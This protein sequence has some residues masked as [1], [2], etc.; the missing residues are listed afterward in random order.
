[1]NRLIGLILFLLFTTSSYA[2]TY[3]IRPGG[4]DRTQCTGLTDA[5]YPGSGTNQAC[6]WSQF[7]YSFTT[8]EYN[9]FAWAISG[10]DTI[11]VRGGPYRIGYQGPNPGDSGGPN[12]GDPFAVAM[13]PIS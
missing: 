10:G 6:A 7:R 2:A 11:I 1:M 9:N 5:D 8:G 12:P 4:G 13:P 3:Y